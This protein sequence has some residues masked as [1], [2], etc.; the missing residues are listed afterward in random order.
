MDRMT[1]KINVNGVLTEWNKATIN[2]GEVTH[3]AFPFAKGKFTVTYNRAVNPQT[4]TLNYD[5]TEEVEIKERSNF[6][7]TM[8]D[9]A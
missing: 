1:I 8:T 9:K 3:L 6:N 7:V 4:G 5:S 2:Y